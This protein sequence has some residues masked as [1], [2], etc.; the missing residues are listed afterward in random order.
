MENSSDKAAL[1]WAAFSFDPRSVFHI[2]LSKNLTIKEG[3]KAGRLPRFSQG[4]ICL[5]VLHV[6][7][8]L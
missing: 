2:V 6:L 3:P 7:S 5:Q 4:T 1:Q 8:K